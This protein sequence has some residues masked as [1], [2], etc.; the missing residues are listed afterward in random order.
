MNAFYLPFY[1]LFFAGF[2]G[3][4]KALKKEPLAG[5]FFFQTVLASIFVYLF[6]VATWFI[7]RRYIAVVMFPAF[8]F[9]GLGVEKLIE[10]MKSKRMKEGLI[11]PGLCILTILITLPENLE[12]ERKDIAAIKEIGDK[13]SLEAGGRGAR[14][15][16]SE[17]RII[18]YANIS[19][20]E[21]ICP[22]PVIEYNGLAQIPYPDLIALLK[23]K[24]VEYFI[25]EEAK[26]KKSPYDFLK[27]VKAQDMIEK[28][29]W[30]IKGE[31]IVLFQYNYQ[32]N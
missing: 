8:F 12:S 20:S 18:T 16:T 25:W 1:I 31:E 4:K 19:S 13:I 11:I 14:I 26:W 2:F 7:E 6:L 22:I 15:A 9:I 21:L 30:E 32:E 17:A 28:G 5:Y 29:Q 27:S 23:E 24:G 10:S 3:V